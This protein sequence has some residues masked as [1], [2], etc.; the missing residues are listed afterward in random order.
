[1]IY[2]LNSVTSSK[3][4]QL[5]LFTFN[6]NN[7][8]FVYTETDFI[9]EYDDIKNETHWLVEYKY[10]GIAMRKDTSL[11]TIDLSIAYAIPLKVKIV[12]VYDS[13]ATAKIL[14]RS[15]ELIKL[16]KVGDKIVLKW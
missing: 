11:A 9:E 16:L 2:V 13:T 10:L 8:I 3:N 6:I 12:N 14:E 7:N 4:L 5:L 15:K 1:M